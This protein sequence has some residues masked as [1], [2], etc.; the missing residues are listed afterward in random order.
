MYTDCTIQFIDDESPLDVTIKAYDSLG[1]EDWKIFFYGLSRDELL[2]ACRTGEIIEG[3]WKVL[4]V[5][6]TYDEL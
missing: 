3:E 1:E 5:G 2:E 4:S 6:E